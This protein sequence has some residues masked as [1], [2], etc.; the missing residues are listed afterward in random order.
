MDERVVRVLKVGERERLFIR[1]MDTRSWLKL[2]VGFL[3]IGIL[4]YVH[5]I[6][7][8]VDFFWNLHYNFEIKVK[9]NNRISP[10]A[11]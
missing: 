9:Y 5:P 4:H 1:S 11:R 8:M 7:I 3:A 6:F 10:I 2:G